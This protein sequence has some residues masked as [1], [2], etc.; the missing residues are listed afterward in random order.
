MKKLKYV[1][2]FL[3]ISGFS[4]ILAITAITLGLQNSTRVTY[5]TK[6][7][8]ILIML[9]AIVLNISKIKINNSY[10]NTYLIFILFYIN[11]LI[12]ELINPNPYLLHSVPMISLYLF[13]HSFLPFTFYLF[14][15]NRKDYISIFK[16][17]LLSSVLFNITIYFIY[18][19]LLIEGVGRL[20]GY[21]TKKLTD[22]AT[23]SPLLLAYNATITLVLS[24]FTLIYHKIKNNQK[25]LYYIAIVTAMPPFL[26]GAS[27]GAILGLIISFMLF[28]IYSKRVSK[29]KLIIFTIIFGSMIV[30][31]ADYYNSSLLIRFTSL[32]EKNQEE[33]LRIIIYKTTF[34]QFLQSPLIGGS[35]QNDKVNHFPH[36]I[37]L[38]A[39]TATGIFGAL[40]LFYLTIKAFKIVLH[41]FKND[42]AL[43]WIG[44]LF[45]IYFIHSL[46]NGNIYSA[47]GFWMFLGILLG[48]KG[49]I[50]ENYY[51]R[52]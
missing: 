29:Y 6:A 45:L 43:S 12:I 33:N 8:I 40:S 17:L 51:K 21:K 14:I 36:N 9:V 47:V 22:D 34:Q 23:L 18:S 19:D 28:L 26:L 24:I 49:I 41:I 10:Y 31:S 35:I 3:N 27:R 25:Y 39:L 46:F 2:T 4:L 42:T 30:V 16:A 37:Y 48:Y 52:R 20:G 1:I 11:K 38:E 50:Y 44:I 13:S 32:F 7:I 15:I 5:P